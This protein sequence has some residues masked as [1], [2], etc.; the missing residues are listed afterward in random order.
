MNEGEGGMVLW[1]VDAIDGGTG[2]VGLWMGIGG[3]N[4]RFGGYLFVTPH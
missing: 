3:T 1:R 4:P 2:W